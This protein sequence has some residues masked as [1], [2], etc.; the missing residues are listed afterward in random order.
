L[1]TP[2]EQRTRPALL[3]I[4]VIAARLGIS[5]RTAWSDYR[6]ACR[7]LRAVGAFAAMLEAIRAAPAGRR[8]LMRCASVECDAE[9]RTLFGESE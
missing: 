8:E 3:P 4:H 7:K 1:N 9:Y 5:E 2:F 6:R